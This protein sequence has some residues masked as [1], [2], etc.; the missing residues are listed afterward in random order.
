MSVQPPPPNTPPTSPT[1]GGYPVTI[2][3]DL[4]DRVARWRPLVQWIL[5]IPHLVVLW[6]LGV[7]AGIVVVIAWF[8]GVI[9]GKVPRTLLDLIAMYLRYSASVNAY[10]GFLHSTY[11]PF[12]ID[13]STADPGKDP[14]VHVD[15]VPQEENRSRLTIFFRYFMLIPQMIVLFFV[16]IAASIVWFIAFF[17]VIVLGRWPEGLREF[18]LGYLRWNQR[19]NAYAYLLTDDYPPFSLR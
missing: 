19:F 6:A 14:H 16:T 18:V 7:V 15:V 2:T 10:A 4:P 9:L 1:P 8:T 12:A 11:P 17:A 5:A 3:F 13:A